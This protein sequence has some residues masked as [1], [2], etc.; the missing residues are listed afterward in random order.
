MVFFR[1]N[2][3]EKQFLQVDGVYKLDEDAKAG[4]RFFRG[5]NG[6]FGLLSAIPPTSIIDPIDDTNRNQKEFG[7]I[8]PTNSVWRLQ[9]Q[10]YLEDTSLVRKFSNMFSVWGSIGKESVLSALRNA[11]NA[12]AIRNENITSDF[13]TNAIAPE[14][15]LS[16]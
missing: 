3:A 14:V 2:G 11:W 12:H 4:E 7:V 13:I 16:Q 9:A 8:A 5:T 1:V 15:S 6:L 10:V